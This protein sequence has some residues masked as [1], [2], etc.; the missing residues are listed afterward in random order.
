MKKLTPRQKRFCEEYV[1]DLNQTQA[2]IRAGY[3]KRSAKEQ[4]SRLLTKDNILDYVQKL[5]DGVFEKLNFT[6][7]DVIQKLD[8]WVNSDITIVLGLSV[9][10]VKSL[11]IEVR[12]LIKSFKHKRKTIK[13]QDKTVVEDYIECSFVDKESALEMINKHNG[14]YKL[15]NSQKGTITVS[16]KD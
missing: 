7:Q 13:T 16:F 1:I 3:A 10:E 12:K 11:P 2:A 6:H 8:Q 15:D 9:D 4:A 14:F 5:K